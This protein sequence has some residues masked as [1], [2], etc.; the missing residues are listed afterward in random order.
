MMATAML[1]MPV[2][3]S[4]Q[5]GADVPPMSIRVT[6]EATVTAAPDQAEIDVAVLTRADTA[7]RAAA[8]NARETTRVLAEMKQ[9]VG[10]MGT[11]STV[12]YSVHPEYRYPR[13]GGE[14]QISGY[15]ATNI[16]RVTLS[17][18]HLREGQREA[19]RRA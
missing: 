9:Q 5:T 3:A 11:T 18:L 12:G 10:T 13:E 17:D 6:A 1:T 8:D 15:A 7:Q 19:P 2:P 14:P 16:V 4:A